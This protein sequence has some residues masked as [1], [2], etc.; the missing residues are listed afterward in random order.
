MYMEA[1]IGEYLGVMPKKA[2]TA[3]KFSNLL[4]NL[5]KVFV[6]K[7]MIKDGGAFCYCY[8]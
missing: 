6:G 4:S 3:T 1:E 8:Y 7:K 5:M 2:I